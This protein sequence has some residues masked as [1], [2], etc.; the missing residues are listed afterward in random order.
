MSWLTPK[1][2][3]TTGNLKTANAQVGN[4]A[5]TQAVPPVPNLE[6]LIAVERPAS[7]PRTISQPAIPSSSHSNGDSGESGDGNLFYAYARKVW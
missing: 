4:G 5:G 3:R 6:N 7:T 2:R 1:R